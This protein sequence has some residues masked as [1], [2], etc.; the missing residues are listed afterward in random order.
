MEKDVSKGPYVC[1]TVMTNLE[2]N[3]KDVK[4]DETNVPW[5]SLTWRMEDFETSL[6][7]PSLYLSC[8]E[9]LARVRQLP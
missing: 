9:L 1:S 6:Y 5:I 8:Q 2:V 7:H 3:W 4:W